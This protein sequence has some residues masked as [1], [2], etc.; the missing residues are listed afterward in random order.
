MSRRTVSEILRV[1][2]SAKGLTVAVSAADYNSA[3]LA[4]FATAL[5]KVGGRLRVAQAQ[6]KTSTELA[7]LVGIGNVD[8]QFY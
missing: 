3:E 1:I 5:A 2:S 8:L 7:R 4:Q 6:D